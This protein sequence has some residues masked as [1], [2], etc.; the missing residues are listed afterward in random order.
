MALVLSGERSSAAAT[1]TP[2]QFIANAMAK[3]RAAFR[4]QTAL[5][6]LLALDEHRLEDLGINRADLFDALYAPSRPTRLLEERRRARA[7]RDVLN[8]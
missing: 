4:Q 5:H 1:S 6:D 3:V 2:F 8:P 7:L